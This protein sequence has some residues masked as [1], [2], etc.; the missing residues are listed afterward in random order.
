MA[1]PLSPIEQALVEALV[2]AFVRALRDSASTRS[3][4]A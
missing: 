3:G 1:G 2:R 4:A